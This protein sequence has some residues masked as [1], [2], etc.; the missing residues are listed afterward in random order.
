MNELRCT[1]E[2]TMSRSHRRL[3]FAISVLTLLLTSISPVFA[4]DATP[5]SEKL[6][7]YAPAEAWRLYSLSPDG[8]MVVG[9]GKEGQS[10]CTFAV[11]SGETI[12]CANLDERDISLRE[13]DI[14]WS[15]N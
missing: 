15:P 3:A 6:T 13:E 9:A 2:E 11:P 4:Q 10:L 8:T 1:K 14:R 7:P 12:A 5:A